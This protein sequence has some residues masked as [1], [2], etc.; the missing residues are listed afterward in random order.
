MQG[1]VDSGHSCISGYNEV[2][3]LRNLPEE[4]KRYVSN[5]LGYDGAHTLPHD[6]SGIKCKDDWPTKSVIEECR[7][8]K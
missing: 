3:I 6:C 2:V 8:M 7:R 4:H 1:T 5:L